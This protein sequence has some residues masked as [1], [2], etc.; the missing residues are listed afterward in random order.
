ML[1]I[2]LSTT[3]KS[4]LEK[5]TRLILTLFLL[6][7][8]TFSLSANAYDSSNGRILAFVNASLGGTFTDNKD[9]PSI[10]VTIAPG[11]LSKNAKLIVYQSKIKGR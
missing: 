11:A 2:S 9:N 8:I 3:G 1:Q 6:L 5:N 4:I 7:L 10:T